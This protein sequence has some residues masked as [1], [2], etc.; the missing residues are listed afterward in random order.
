VW[1]YYYYAANI[2]IALRVKSTTGNQVFYLFGDH[3]GSTSL[4]TDPSG[5]PVNEMRFKAWGGVRYVWGIAVMNYT[6]TGQREEIVL[7]LAYYNARWYDSYLNRWTQPDIIVPDS[8]QGVQAWDRYA[9]TNNNPVRYNDPS[10][11]CIWDGCILEIVAIGALIGAGISYGTQVAEN[12]SNNGWSGEA[13]TNV[14]GVS[15]AAAAV[16]GAVGVGI[17]LAGAAIVGT[18]LAAT[19]ATGAVGGVISG[20][21]SR[22]TENLLTGQNIVSGLGNPTDMLVDGTVGGLTA[23]IGYG[24][25]RVL[26]SSFHSGKFP[27]TS[28]SRFLLRKTG[29][30]GDPG[31]AEYDLS[32]TRVKY[33][34]DLDGPAHRG[35]GTPHLQQAKWNTP[36]S[37]QPE[38][39]GWGDTPGKDLFSY[40]QFKARV[41]GFYMDISN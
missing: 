7:G 36:P 39:N 9:Y 11:H 31:F 38:F 35:I 41:I 29:A 18:G 32:T 26:Q 25:Q 6:F 21:A 17:G 16:A 37:G 10:G 22:A 20:Q 3:L 23:G 19:L 13:F 1:K 30:G 28:T 2:R 34:V 4:V 27:E 12:I 40:D 5:N 14:D 33:R 15:I 24:T 8:L